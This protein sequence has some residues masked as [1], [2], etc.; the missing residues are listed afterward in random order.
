M[1][2]DFQRAATK[3]AE[4]LVQFEINKTPVSPFH[5]LKRLDGV[6]LIPFS[7]IAHR[8]DMSREDLIETFGSESRAAVTSMLH[9]NGKTYYFVAY[10]QYMPTVL[11]Q[12]ALARELG[13]IVL[14]HDG[15]RPVDV[16]MA[17][18]YCFAHHL[19]TPRA[20]IKALQ[21]SGYPIT[22]EMFNNI[23]SCNRDC[24]ERMKLLPGV[25]VPAELNK[26]IR[27]M[28]SNSIHDFFHYQKK[29]LPADHS[30][31]IDF[32]SFM[33]GYSE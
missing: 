10:S 32:G 27:E 5:I 13:H 22:I 11:I 15:S 21:E 6:Q 28:F 2:P 33:D 17:E 8:V 25:D 4:I 30:E 1:T 24:L 12:R 16:R 20:V 26:R 3:A 29:F 14:G 9:D 18:A 7:E 31:I 19:L 23:T